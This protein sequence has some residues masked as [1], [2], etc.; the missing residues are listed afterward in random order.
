MKREDEALEQLELAVMLPREDINSEHERR[1]AVELLAKHW[2]R[3]V[4]P[5]T[6]EDPPPT[7]PP[8]QRRS[9]DL[10]LSRRSSLDEAPAT[11]STPF[12]CCGD[13]AHNSPSDSANESP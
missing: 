8:R 7:P 6:F 2:G 3:V 11:P 13:S 12:A 9:F 4:K 1:D 10:S 5:P